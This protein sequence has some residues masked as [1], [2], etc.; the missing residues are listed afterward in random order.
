M[1]NQAN[2]G[3][4]YCGRSS[5]LACTTVS[6]MSSILIPLINLVLEHSDGLS[7]ADVERLKLASRFVPQIPKVVLFQPA[8]SILD[9]YLHHRNYFFYSKYIYHSS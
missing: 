9:K 7:G 3:A 4:H 6:V 2:K 5:E 8:E 1:A